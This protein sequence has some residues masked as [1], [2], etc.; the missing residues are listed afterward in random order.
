MRASTTTAVRVGIALAVASLA[1]AVPTYTVDGVLGGTA[2][3]NGSARGTALVVAVLAVPV[4]VVGMVLTRRGALLGAPVW[5][6]AT[7]YLAYN[8]VM[9]GFAT[10][11]N[12]L[13]LAYVAMLG[14]SVAGLVTLL[15]AVDHAELERHVVTGRM[16]WVAGYVW[17][18]VALNSVAWLGRVVP[19]L[20][21]ERPAFLVGTG[22][23]TN[24][25]FVQDLAFW[26]PVAALV[27]WWVWRGDRLGGLFAGGLLVFWLLEAVGVAVDQFYGHAADPASDVA[28]AAG[29]WLFVGQAA[30]V[31]LVA[32]AY[33]RASTR[34][35][36]S[37]S[38]SGDSPA[39][40]GRS[41]ERHQSSVSRMVSGS[42]RG[43]S[44]VA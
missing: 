21:D 22:L 26:L 2:V 37:R 7:G 44:P 3:M 36:R 6:G 24:P 43:E 13:F 34:A 27:G 30:V 39:P 41:A 32:V 4:L 28:T 40:D 9:F 14:L 11:F 31:S 10:P 15:R 20:G 33:F 16:R 18:V 1:A 38:A 12:A 25:V 42:G 19:E 35:S 5:L 23:T 8:A 29:G 17:L